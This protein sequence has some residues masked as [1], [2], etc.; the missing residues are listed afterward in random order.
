MPGDF[1][2]VSACWS[3][4]SIRSV[5]SSGSGFSISATGLALTAGLVGQSAR[6]R[7]P[8]GRVVTGLV[9]EDQTV[10]MAL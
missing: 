8:G 5:N 6:I 1:Q 3:S 7:L 10:E 2:S 9:Q 4:R